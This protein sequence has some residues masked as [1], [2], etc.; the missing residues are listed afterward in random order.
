MN[1]L[2]K[3]IEALEAAR[4]LE[5]DERYRSYTIGTRCNIQMYPESFNHLVHDIGATV[6]YD[7]NWYNVEPTMGEMYFFYKGYKIIAL[8]EKGRTE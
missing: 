5:K 7:P 4:A 2:D 3:M 1:W 8:W 6:T